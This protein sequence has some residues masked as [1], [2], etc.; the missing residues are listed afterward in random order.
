M[1]RGYITTIPNDLDLSKLPKLFFLELSANGDSVKAYAYVL[2]GNRHTPILMDRPDAHP[3]WK[4]IS[5]C[6]SYDKVLALLIALKSQPELIND[7]EDNPYT[8]E[9]KPTFSLSHQNNPKYRHHRVPICFF[10]L[11]YLGEHTSSH[12]DTLEEMID[13][14]EKRKIEEERALSMSQCEKLTSK[15]SANKWSLSL[16]VAGFF[17]A[18]PLG[19]LL[20]GAAGFA[21]D[22]VNFYHYSQQSFK[23]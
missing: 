1:Q 11:P 3:I 14:V 17:A 8:N 6:N 21:K 13:F 18:G 12:D 23:R 10:S 7:N 19:A 22:Q 9:A 16:S 15:C 5:N 20:G 4:K 2:D